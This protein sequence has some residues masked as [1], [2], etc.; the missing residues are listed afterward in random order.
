MILRSHLTLRLGLLVMLT[1]LVVGCERPASEVIWINGASYNCGPLG[2]ADS[3][4]GEDRLT[5]VWTPD[6]TRL[7]F[8]Y[9][10]T[11][12]E[13]YG[14]SPYIHTTFWVV[15]AEGAQLEK[16]V[17]ANPWHISR[18]GHH[19]D[20]S[21]DGRRF[22]YASCEY[23]TGHGRRF[24]EH[25]ERG[26]YNYE[27]VVTNM[28]GTKKRRLTRNDHLDHYPV[29]SPDGD[30][31]AFLSA[32]SSSRMQYDQDHLELQIMTSE[33]LDKKRVAPPG[34][35]GLTLAP[36]VWS[37]DGDRLAFLANAE[38]LR[39]QFLRNL[40]TVKADGSELTLIAEGVVS[41]PAWSPDGQRLAVARFASVDVALFTLAADGSD[42]ERIATITTRLKLEREYIPYWFSIYAMSWSPDGAQLLFSCDAGVC[43]VNLEDGQVTGLENPQEAWP[44]P[45]FAAWSPDG[46]RIAVYTPA[47]LSESVS[48]TQLYTV[49]RDGTDR[50]D[51]I[52]LD[53]D[54][55]LAPANPPQDEL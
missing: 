40:Y 44:G 49:A 11:L 48:P 9:V 47:A 6:S 39:F 34:T 51:L 26:K 8:N 1:S 54:G 43:V 33:G 35:Y 41:A 2:H 15:D 20:I 30:H 36:P 52:R 4:A 46:G 24:G 13:M 55:N 42:S 10:S 22:V 23:P 32:R 21:P 12:G 53:A 18:Y 27:I 3:V 17:E 29:W 19:A 37:P 38:P 25:P 50:R 7:V 14:R 16:L 45:Y 31:I 5:L 28:D